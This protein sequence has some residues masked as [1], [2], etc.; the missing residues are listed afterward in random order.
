MACWQFHPYCPHD[1]C[2][3]TPGNHPTLPI[4]G[5]VVCVLVANN[6]MPLCCCVVPCV[7]FSAAVDTK[8]WHHTSTRYHQFIEDSMDTMSGSKACSRTVRQ[9]LEE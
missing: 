2:V 6:S 9:A 7:L 5:C 1:T 8:M 4:K 3:G